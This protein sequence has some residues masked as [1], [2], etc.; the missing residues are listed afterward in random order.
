MGRTT[1]RMLI[2]IIRMALV[3]MLGVTGCWFAGTRLVL[4]EWRVLVAAKRNR[5]RKVVCWRCMDKPV[6]VA[7]RLCNLCTAAAASSL[8]ADAGKDWLKEWSVD[9][10]VESQKAGSVPGGVSV[11]AVLVDPSILDDPHNMDD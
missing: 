8:Y 11:D 2:G 9:Q 10:L 5:V 3:R 1:C 7:G 4:G 6:Q